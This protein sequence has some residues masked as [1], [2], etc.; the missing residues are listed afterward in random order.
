MA[1]A[2]IAQQCTAPN[3]NRG[4]F[5]WRA[6]SADLNWQFIGPRDAR[7]LASPIFADSMALF[8]WI[9]AKGLER[10]PGLMGRVVLP[11]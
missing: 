4:S 8:D 7:K 10:E 3:G 6:P 2:H 1:F 5:L 11:E 9:D